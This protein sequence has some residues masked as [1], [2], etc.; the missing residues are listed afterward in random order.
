MESFF[1]SGG[2]FSWSESIISVVF[3]DFDTLST[4]G[5]IG[6][7]TVALILGFDFGVSGSG[8]LFGAFLGLKKLEIELCFLFPMV[9]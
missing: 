4:F 2:V 9:V 6:L 1:P 7:E 3:S 8:T 5:V